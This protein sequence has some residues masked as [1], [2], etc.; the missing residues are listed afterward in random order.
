MN[1]LE[2]FKRICNFEL[3]GTP[4]I[5]SVWAWPETIDRWY[6]EGMPV[7]NIETMKPVNM[8]F[9][10]YDFQ[11]EYIYPRGSIRGLG[12]Y[13]M[14]PW[15]VELDPLFKREVLEE[16]DQYQVLRDYDGAIVRRKKQG[17]HSIP[18]YLEYPVKDQGTWDLYKER[19]EPFSPGRWPEGWDRI[20]DKWLAWPIKEGQEG[21]SWEMR[22]F[23]LGMSNL[24]LYGD[25]R[26]YMGLEELS[27]ALFR[28][29]NMVLEMMDRQLWLA[30]EML[31]KVYQ[32][33]I[34]LDYVFIW[35]DMCFNKGPLVSPKWI[36]EFMVPRYR[37]FTDLLY[38]NGCKCI[39]V[40]SDGDISQLLPIWLDCGIN[41][42][43]PLE[44]TSKM[45][46]RAI[47]KKYGNNIILIGNIDKRAL[48]AGKAEIDEEI[49]LVK[50][51]IKH[52]GYFVNVDHFVPPDVPYANMK[53][54]VDEVL[55][56]GSPG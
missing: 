40:D 19:L 29:K 56:L 45:E 48:A 15:I 1:S 20:H 14:D 34:T 55:K 3:K 42:T 26:N 35:E 43:F 49:E 50:D 24:S 53:Y 37:Q 10:G 30:V 16:D 11:T 52:G 5:W 8:H 9:L 22:D 6:A 2:H 13:G 41:A 17:D 36:R 27:K 21:Q 33:N 7:E 46:A 23:P 31:K 18:Q 25:M 54:F 12:R 47:R 51:M 4:F 44:R 39:I 28:N 38:A 32:H